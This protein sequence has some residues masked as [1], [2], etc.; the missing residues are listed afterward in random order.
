[1]DLEQKDTALRTIRTIDSLDEILPFPD[2]KLNPTIK[3]LVSLARGYGLNNMYDIANDLIVLGDRTKLKELTDSQSGQ[4]LSYQ[5]EID[6]DI[7][8]GNALEVQKQLTAGM[9]MCL[10]LATNETFKIPWAS[11]YEEK[12]VFG[13]QWENGY[14]VFKRGIV[15]P[16]NYI[17]IMNKYADSIKQVQDFQMKGLATIKR[18][19]NVLSKTN[20]G[21]TK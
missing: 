20:E 14:L 2:T 13:E 9:V 7:N 4:V 17:E 10:A 21:E 16:A 5:P 3:T 1:M 6:L 8:M 15:P 18:S 19:V 11:R 12:G